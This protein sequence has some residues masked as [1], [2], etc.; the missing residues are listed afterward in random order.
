[1]SGRSRAQ[2][3]LQINAPNYVEQPDEKDRANEPTIDVYADVPQSV[4]LDDVTILK[5]NVGNNNVEGA[6]IPPRYPNS[7]W[8][9]SNIAVFDYDFGS[10][11]TTTL[12][13]SDVANT[14]KTLK[15]WGTGIFT[16]GPVTYNNGEFYLNKSGWWEIEFCLGIWLGASTTD[17]QYISQDDVTKT[18]TAT[19]SYYN[20]GIPFSYSIYINEQGNN[21]NLRHVANGDGRELNGYSN[22]HVYLKRI[23]GIGSFGTSFPSQPVTIQGNCKSTAHKIAS[24]GFVK[25]TLLSSYEP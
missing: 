5:G 23:R 2:K 7:R 4:I 12:T 24:N 6:L 22:S 9:L 20:P 15:A 10:T 8:N 17:L 21:K 1:M 25:F 16:R 18:V 3:R 11:N 14:D 19:G 13:I